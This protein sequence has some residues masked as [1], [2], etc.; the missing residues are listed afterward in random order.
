[1]NC[2]SVGRM[3]GERLGPLRQQLSQI[4]DPVKPDLDRTLGQP[5]SREWVKEL[6]G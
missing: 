1:M 3:S 2:Y 6:A 5:R 4:E